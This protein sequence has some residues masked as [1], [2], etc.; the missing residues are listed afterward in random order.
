MDLRAELKAQAADVEGWLEAS[1]PAAEDSAAPRL[2]QAMRYSLH[3]GGK[4]LRPVLCAWTCA[5]RAK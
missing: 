1:L 3:A 4:R 2:V 5:A